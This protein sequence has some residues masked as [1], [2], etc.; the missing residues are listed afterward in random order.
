MFERSS[1]SLLCSN[2]SVINSSICI[3]A[4]DAEDD[5][6]SL[7]DGEEQPAPKFM[8]I[9]LTNLQINYEAWKAEVIPEDREEV[10]LNEEEGKEQEEDE[11]EGQDKEQQENKE[12]E[13]EMKV[14][15]IV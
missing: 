13:Q 10:E 12:E 7:E 3:A 11:E 15:I 14:C 2:N 6:F 9:I 1:N 8:S 4:G 5:A